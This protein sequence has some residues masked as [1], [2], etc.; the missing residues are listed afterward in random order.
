MASCTAR[1]DVR[2]FVGELVNVVVGTGAAGAACTVD[3]Q[4]VPGTVCAN[5]ACAAVPTAGQACSE[6]NCADLQSCIQGVCAAGLPDGT[7]CTHG[8]E[9][10]SN[11]CDSG[12]CTVVAVSHIICTL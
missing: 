2:G 1:V 7:A 10:Q 3:T 12:K 9:C 4:C 8:E 5:S 11:Q 6:Q